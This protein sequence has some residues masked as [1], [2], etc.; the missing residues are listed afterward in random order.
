MH[1]PILALKDKTSEIYGF[2]RENT[3]KRSSIDLVKNKRVFDDTCFID[4]L[5]NKY[6]INKVVIERWATP[7]WGY[8][9]LWKGRQI[10]ID[11][12]LGFI[13]KIDFENL[14][15]SLLTKI[16]SKNVYLK[17]EK[18]KLVRAATDFSSLFRIFY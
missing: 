8:S 2:E 9:L 10:F 14:K 16:Q 7:L 11:F 3:L 4:S 13:E 1:Y 17:D 15:Q 5:G 18:I 12:E 6:Q